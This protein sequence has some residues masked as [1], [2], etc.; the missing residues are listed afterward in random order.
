SFVFVAH[1]CGSD[2]PSGPD[3]SDFDRQAMLENWADNI[4]IPAFASFSEETEQLKSAAENF[5]AE[6]SQQS[7]DE[8][9]NA[10]ESAY[11][12][13]QHVSMFE[14]GRAMEL[15]FRDNLNLY[16]TDTE[17]IQDN[18]EQDSYNLE[19]PSLT[20]SQGFPAL[21]YLLYGLA[22]DDS[23]I[24]AYY[25]DDANA[26]SFRTYVLD[27]A[28]RIDDLTQEVS[29]YWAEEYRDEFVENAGDGAN[30][31][32]DMMVNDY[33]FYYE[34]F[35]RAGKVGIPAG[36]FSDIG[37]LPT[38]VEAPYRQDLSK[39]LLLE[40]LEATQNFFNGVHFNSGESGESLNTYLDF[41]NSIKNGADLSSLINEQFETARD[42]IETLDENFAQQ[43]E[44]DN[45]GMLAAY[46][47]L[48]KN[49][50]LLKVDMLQALNIN[51][52]YVDADGD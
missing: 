28:V 41:L 22:E 36:V 7:L 47:E 16:P 24:L 8:M 34:K 19:L 45:S 20:D 29:T 17:E 2:G 6:P 42:E 14:M 49:V 23:E 46:D 38:H 18:M 40:A 9:R 31:S 32:V 33:I 25:T 10:W 3:S 48:Q 30:A 50:V 13:F 12:S 11:I 35:L 5:S 26:E 44:E 15:R 51:V 39:A 21:D 1:S 4:I 37:P 27:L 43:I 52:D